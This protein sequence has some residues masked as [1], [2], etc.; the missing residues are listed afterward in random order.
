V[1]INPELAAL[2]A[3]AY[4]AVADHEADMAKPGAEG[5]A[6]RAEARREAKRQ[7]AAA[8]RAMGRA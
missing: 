7:R 1:T 6:Y 3:A 2:R 4:Q 8:R 5:D